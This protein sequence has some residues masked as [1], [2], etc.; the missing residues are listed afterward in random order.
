MAVF[1]L[2]YCHEIYSKWYY[3]ELALRTG[4]LLKVDLTNALRQGNAQ[5]PV[6]GRTVAVNG[7][8][9]AQGVLEAR[10]VW[11]VKGPLSWGPDKQG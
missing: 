11:K 5:A 1:F 10:T 3:I 4:K 2:L 7:D 6:I 9:N 8:F